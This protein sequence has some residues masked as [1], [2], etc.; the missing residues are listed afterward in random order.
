MQLVWFSVEG[1]HLKQDLWPSGDTMGWN[2][3]MM[4]KTGSFLVQG[5]WLLPHLQI[6]RTDCM[7]Q[8]SRG[9]PGSIRAS[10][11]WATLKHQEEVASDSTEPLPAAGD[12]GPH[13]PSWP[14]VSGGSLL[15]WVSDSG[16]YWLLK[17]V[18][19]SDYY[20]LLLFPVGTNT[21]SRGDL[22]NI[23]CD[24]MGFGGDSRA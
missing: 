17:L 7:D 18:W 1:G 16:C 9:G 14:I 23:K 11:A 24:C 13:L 20:P 2:S 12:R 22:E 19:L 21:A 3:P 6:C 10:R 15:A 8:C 4:G 5:R